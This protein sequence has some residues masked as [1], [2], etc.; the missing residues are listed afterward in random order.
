MPIVIQ[1]EG[2]YDGTQFWTQQEVIELLREQILA[3]VADKM[4]KSK[5]VHETP[6]PVRPEPEA[7]SS[8]WSRKQSKAPAHTPA[9]QP[10]IP[11]VTVEVQQDQFSFRAETQYGLFETLL[12]RAVLVT[13]DV[14]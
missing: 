7:K 10:T 9:A 13:V 8:F 11:P 14:K 12:A 5:S 3:A 4:P 1:L 2:D 6:L